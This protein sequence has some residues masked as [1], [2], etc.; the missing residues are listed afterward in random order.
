MAHL[1]DEFGEDL[2][3]VVAVVAA[4]GFDEPQNDTTTEK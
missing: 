3:R 1:V 4:G 2:A